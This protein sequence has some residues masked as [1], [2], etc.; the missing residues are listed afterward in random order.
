MSIKVD[1][2]TI[3]IAGGI[4]AILIFVSGLVLLCQP[5]LTEIN[6]SRAREKAYVEETL[7]AKELLA[8]KNIEGV[9]AQLIPQDKVSLM[10]DMIKEKAKKYN[11]QLTLARPP[12]VGPTT[13]SISGRV[14]FDMQAAS[15]LKDLGAFMTAIRNMPEG[16]VGIEAFRVLPDEASADVVNTKITFI[17]L[18]AKDDR[19]K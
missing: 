5:M 6:V 12:F 19:K 8:K 1:K 3:L 13:E 18:V 14:L 15:S 4:G 17:L 11:V 16:L 2:K 10:M 7:V 9:V